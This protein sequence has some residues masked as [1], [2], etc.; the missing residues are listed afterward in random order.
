MEPFPIRWFD[1]LPSTNMYFHHLL[2]K[3]PGV[4]SGTVVAT[5][6]QTAGRGRRDRVWL[7]M[8]NK[9][10]AFTV[11][12]RTYAPAEHVPSLPMA[13]ALALADA[14]EVYGIVA[15]GSLSSSNA[16]ATRSDQPLS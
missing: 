16:T 2:A 15:G 13:V 5:G 8:E 4:P 1:T 14:L 11:L 6:H 10:L 12:Q 9:D 3:E 7:S